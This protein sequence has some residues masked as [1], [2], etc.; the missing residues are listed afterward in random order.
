MSNLWIYIVMAMSYGIIAGGV[1][2]W[3]SPR[4]RG[5]WRMMLRST[6]VYTIVGVFLVWLFYLVFK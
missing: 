3:M 6:G 4:R 2:T 5:N 1:Y